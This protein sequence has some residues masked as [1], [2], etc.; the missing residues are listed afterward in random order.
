MNW[1]GF[2]FKNLFFDNTGKNCHDCKHLNFSHCK[3]HKMK[4]EE[5]LRFDILVNSLKEKS[6]NTVY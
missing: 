3:F 4:H 1:E 6:R 5:F 2:F